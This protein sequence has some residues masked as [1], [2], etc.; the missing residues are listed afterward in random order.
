[1]SLSRSILTTLCTAI[2]LFGAGGLPITAQKKGDDKRN[3]NMPPPAPP[4]PFSEVRRDS[5]LNGFHLVTYETSA[6]RVKCDVVLRSG[7]MFDLQGKSGLALMTQATLLGVN[8]QLKE[9]IS[10]LKGEI[11]WGVNSDSTWF[12]LEVPAASLDNALEILA[13]Q[14][15]VENIRADSFKRAQA[16]QIER[17]ADS[18]SS[19]TPA[20]SADEAFLAALYREHPYGRTVEGNEKTNTAVVQGD[21]YD[22]ERRFYLANNASIVVVGPVNHDRV[23]RTLKLLFGGWVK[24]AIVPS[25]FR[26]PQR[27]TEVRVVKVEAPNLSKVELRGGV[28]GLRAT[29]QDYLIAQVLARILEARLKRDASVQGGDRVSVEALARVLPGPIFFSASIAPDRA[30]AFSRA[31]TDGFAAMASEIVS[32]EE[33]A[34]AKA[35]LSSERAAMSIGDQLRQIEFYSLPRNY[36]LTFAPRLDAVT[37]ADIQRVGRR[38]LTANA[39]TVVVFGPVG[40]AFKPQT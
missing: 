38:L 20:G 36:P 13:R 18:K 9:E 24:G 32:A 29:D 4:T 33:L 11:D 40:E 6:E 34:A 39:L 7:A 5:L 23:L 31:A 19:M 10:S 12:H 35:S 2:L 37:A 21:V 17:V 26:Q 16:A 8:P 15:V 3:A 27:T 1:M 30:Q 25:T 22:F 28:I 14:V